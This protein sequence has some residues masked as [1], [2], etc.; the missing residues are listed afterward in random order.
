M[1]KKV[2]AY[3]GMAAAVATIW[4]IMNSDDPKA[5]LPANEHCND[6]LRRAGSFAASHQSLNHVAP[7]TP[8]R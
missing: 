1:T 3:A 4:F 2:I 8:S 6:S 7:Y 5:D